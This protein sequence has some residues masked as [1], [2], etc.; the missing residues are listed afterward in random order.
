[1]ADIL[2]EVLHYKLLPDI[3]RGTINNYY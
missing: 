2:Q 1:M 3:H